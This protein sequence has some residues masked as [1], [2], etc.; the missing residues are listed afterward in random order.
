MAE[1]TDPEYEMAV[2]I[3]LEEERKRLEEIEL[4]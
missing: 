3:S 1:E 2:R 4:K